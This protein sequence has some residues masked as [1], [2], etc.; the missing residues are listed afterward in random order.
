MSSEEKVEATS[1]P[2]EQPA[3]EDKPAA[4]E[5]DETKPDITGGE[6]SEQVAAAST[7]QGQE[8]TVEEPDDEEPDDGVPIVLVTGASGFI[9]TH[10]IKQLL[11]QGRYRIRGTVR[12]KKRKEKV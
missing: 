1:P 2:E 7:E 9:A 11:E 4:G 6:A 5:K 10:L 12:S 3:S 8:A